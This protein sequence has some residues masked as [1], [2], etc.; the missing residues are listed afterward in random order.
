M[1]GLSNTL[2]NLGQM[3]SPIV[4]GVLYEKLRGRS[5]AGLPGASAPF[6]AA[7][8]VLALALVLYPLA[9]RHAPGKRRG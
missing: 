1:V 3:T 5:L 2:N 4:A 6:L 9:R 8:L 7:A